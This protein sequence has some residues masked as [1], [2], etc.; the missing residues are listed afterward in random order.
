MAYIFVMVHI[1]TLLLLLL[2][3]TLQCAADK[4]AR[5]VNLLF[6]HPHTRTLAIHLDDLSSKLRLCVCVCAEKFI[7]GKFRIIANRT[8]GSR[9]CRSS[10]AT[11]QAAQRSTLTH[12]SNHPPPATDDDAA[13]P[14]DCGAC[15]KEFTG[16]H[17][18]AFFFIHFFAVCVY[19]FGC[20]R[21]FSSTRTMM[22]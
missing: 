7:C 14:A 3:L 15:A 22:G 5:N 9:V 19:I 11:S 21:M 20:T 17:H 18:S 12:P 2:L 16:A 6:A 4:P 1:P 13:R 10:V 8:S